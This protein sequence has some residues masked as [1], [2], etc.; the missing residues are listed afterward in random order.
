MTPNTDEQVHSRNKKN[1]QKRN[2]NPNNNSELAASSNCV[3]YKIVLII[4]MFLFSSPA[5]GFSFVLDRIATNPPGF[6]YIKKQQQQ[7]EQH[8]Q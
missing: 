3:N 2:K 1:E 7:Q 5:R 8:Q 4:V 6:L